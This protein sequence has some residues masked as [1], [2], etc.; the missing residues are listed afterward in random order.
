MKWGNP[1]ILLW[2]PLAIPLLWV[3]FV[4]LRRRRRGLEELVDP[5]MIPVLAPCGRACPS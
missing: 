5:A 1:D 4:L 3:L 2:L